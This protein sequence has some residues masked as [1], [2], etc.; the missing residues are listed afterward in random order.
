MYNDQI[1]KDRRRELR[2]N[3]TEVEGI[4]WNKLRNR[5]FNNLK[6]RRQYDE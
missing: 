6:F 3:K 5:K 2:K 1:Q 4:L